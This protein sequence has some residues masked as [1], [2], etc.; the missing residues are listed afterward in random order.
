[1]PWLLHAR[2]C[3]AAICSGLT[4]A[5]TACLAPGGH[6]CS[7]TPQAPPELLPRSP[8]PGLAQWGRAASR[9]GAGQGLQA[10]ARKTSLGKVGGSW[11]VL[12]GG[13]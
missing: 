3:G 10:G 12:G 6:V 5:P 8:G 2:V 1:M 13:S 9:S 11:G 4:P 7:R